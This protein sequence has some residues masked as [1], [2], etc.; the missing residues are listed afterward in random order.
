M[1]KNEKNWVDSLGR[2]FSM[3]YLSNKKK[4]FL[5]KQAEKKLLIKGVRKIIRDLYNKILCRE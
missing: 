5:P 2:H 1:A 4:H 3:N